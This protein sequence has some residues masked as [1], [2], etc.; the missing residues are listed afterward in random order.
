MIK[1]RLKLYIIGCLLMAVNSIHAQERIDTN[2]IYNPKQEV[3]DTL[4]SVV[5][6][7]SNAISSLLEKKIAVNIARPMVKGFRIQ[8]YSVSGVNSTDK[9]NKQKAEFLIN[10][11]NSSI[12]IVYSEPYFKLRIGDFRTKLEALA[13]L[14]SI[15]KEYPFAFIVTDNINYPKL[16]ANKYQEPEK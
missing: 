9:V 4:G 16:Q 10:N 3:S 7:Q 8:I 13:Y 6:H 1:T 14:Q 11:P 2:F 5:Y 12:Y 15:N